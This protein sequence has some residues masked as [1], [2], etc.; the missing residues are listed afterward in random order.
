MSVSKKKDFYYFEFDK[1]VY[2]VKKQRINKFQ[3]MFQQL[4][5]GMPHDIEENKIV[6]SIQ[7][8][9]S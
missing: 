4:V 9:L 3:K 5:D 8:G 7:S 1:K 2:A 6:M